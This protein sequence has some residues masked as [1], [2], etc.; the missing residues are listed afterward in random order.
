MGRRVLDRFAAVD[1]GLLAAGIAYNAV[2]A[3]IPLALL[4]SGI[5]GL[6][7]TDPQ[8]R[9]DV[10][11]AIST[12]FPPLAGMIDQI[13]AGLSQTSPSA[14]ILG[15]VLAGWGTSRLFATLES[16]IIQLETTSRRRSFVRQT[17]RRIGSVLVVAGILLLALL[18]VPILHVVRDRGDESV[19][20]GTAL[21]IA[22]GLLP[23]L[24]A[25]LALAIM[26]RVMPIVQPTTGQ[27]LVPAVLGGIALYI[28]TEGFVFL[29]PRIFAGNVVYGTLGAL[30]VGLIWLD[31]VFMI[32]LIAASW[33][34]ERRLAASEPP[35]TDAADAADAAATVAPSAPLTR[36]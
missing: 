2:F 35:R 6:L 19:V 31:L 20:V 15:L 3:L 9:L 11:A 16:A 33:T 1:G 24:L 14:T 28:L 18:A 34:I 26:F 32:V 23:P 10:V 22:I 13:L 4:A 12:A 27:V 21:G 17:A 30:L 29:A 36:R 25:A 5:A 8:A 7:L